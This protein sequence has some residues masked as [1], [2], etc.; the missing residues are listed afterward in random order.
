MDDAGTKPSTAEEILT[1]VDNAN[2]RLAWRYATPARW[3][4]TAERWQVLRDGG[5]GGSQTTIYETWEFFGGLLA[6]LLWF[7][8]STK[9]QSSFDG[10]GRALKDRVEH[11]E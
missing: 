2:F 7:F 9:L 10:M 4:I 5:P 8:M 6:Y 11:V 3:L 1:H